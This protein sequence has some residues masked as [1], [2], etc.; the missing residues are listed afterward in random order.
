M[1][2]TCFGLSAT[3]IS[4]PVESVI[5]LPPPSL[6]RQ[7]TTECGFS[8]ISCSFAF[9]PATA[10][11]SRSFARVIL[12][13]HP[14]LTKHLTAPR[15]FLALP[16]SP[17]LHVRSHSGSG[18]DSLARGGLFSD[19]KPDCSFELAGLLAALFKDILKTP[20][21]FG[22]KREADHARESKPLAGSVGMP[23]RGPDRTRAG[24]LD[25]QR[26]LRDAPSVRAMEQDRDRFCLFG[27][28]SD[29][30]TER[31]DRRAV[32]RE[33]RAQAGDS[34]RRGLNCGRVHTG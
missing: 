33:I 17:R 15:E 27:V 9:M 16:L 1:L 12:R 28:C 31:A 18:L 26:F 13:A 14:L 5:R 32:V 6:G 4:F 8:S 11:I 7:L 20:R 19:H 29:V 22:G 21:S 30:R 25:L 3:S 2:F 10:I 24:C 34:G 23:H